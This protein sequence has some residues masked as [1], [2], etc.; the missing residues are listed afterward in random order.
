MVRATTQTTARQKLVELVFDCLP[1]APQSFESDRR[2]LNLILRNLVENSIKFTPTGGTVTVSVGAEDDGATV[3][4]RVQELRP[5][6][7]E[8]L[9]EQLRTLPVAADSELGV[10][11]IRRRSRGH[12]VIC[13]VRMGG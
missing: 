7:W 11:Q 6:M 9:L 10:T 8:K 4:L 5:K 1:G 13:A 12:S 2:L 3:I